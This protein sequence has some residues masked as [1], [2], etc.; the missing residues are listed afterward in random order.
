MYIRVMQISAE[1]VKLLCCLQEMLLISEIGELTT[2]GAVERLEKRNY[3]L[4]QVG[5]K[6]DAREITQ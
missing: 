4:E 3:C 1:T 2:K 6:V 5:G